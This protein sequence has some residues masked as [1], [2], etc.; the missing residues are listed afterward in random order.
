MILLDQ[1]FLMA[2]IGFAIFD[3]FLLLFKTPTK[4]VI[5]VSGIYL[6]ITVVLGSTLCPI[7]FQKTNFV[8]EANNNFIP[9]ATIIDIMENANALLMLLQIGGNIA[10]FVPAGVF[11][12]ML[13]KRNH[14]IVIPLFIMLVP[15]FIEV[16]QHVVGIA[17][18]HNYRSFDVDDII[19]GT[20]GCLMGYLFGI[21]VLSR[22][23]LLHRH[24]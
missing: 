16:L 20:I 19:L 8:V 17:I 14:R 13:V 3:L 9:F 22:I 6:Y 7:P 11:L 24:R 12:Y 21:I 4:K 10:L 1:F 15:I 18:G 5:R 2:F 23:K